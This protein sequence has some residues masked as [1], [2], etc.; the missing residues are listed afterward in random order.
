VATQSQSITSRETLIVRPPHSGSLGRQLID[1]LWEW[2]RRMSSRREL[3]LLSEL[4]LRDIG[5]P[6]R[7]EAE[8][9]KP[10]WRA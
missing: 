6:D 4:E 8:K 7:L 5:Y 10:F 9:A 2:R 1:T 3:A